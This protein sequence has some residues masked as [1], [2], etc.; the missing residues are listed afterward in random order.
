MQERTLVFLKKWWLLFALMAFQSV[1]SILVAWYGGFTHKAGRASVTF[2]M[3]Y[4]TVIFSLAY[5]ARGLHVIFRNG[6]TKFILAHR[7][8]LGISF[9]YSFIFHLCQLPFLHPTISMSPVMF[10]IQLIPI[11]F[12]NLM[13]L[14][15]IPAIE[16]S[17]SRSLWKGIHQWGSVVIWIALFKNYI[18]IFFVPSLL[19]DRNIFYLGSFLV[20]ITP[21]VRLYLI[22]RRKQRRT[23]V[24]EEAY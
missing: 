13:G 21:F 12:I 8:I 3:R 18:L 14:T 23:P 10:G 15:S 2:T 7:K 11:A 17:I 1:V 9:T 16:K 5:M 24:L 4:C 19:G 20:G 22:I 6:V